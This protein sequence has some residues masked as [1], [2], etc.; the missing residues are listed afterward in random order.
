[1]L[2]LRSLTKRYNRV[3]A[4][5]NLDL[6]IRPGEIYGYLGPNGS[7]KS[8]KLRCQLGCSYPIRHHRLAIL[9]CR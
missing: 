1:M 6:T 7:G 3:P 4:V 2:E 9:S 5:E 8:T